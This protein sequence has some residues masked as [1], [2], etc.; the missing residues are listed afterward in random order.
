MLIEAG[1]DVNAKD[2]YEMTPKD[3]LASNSVAGNKLLSEH[4]AKWG[5]QLPA[6]VPQWDSD[7]LAYMGPGE[8]P[9]ALEKS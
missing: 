7:E 8:S 5:R 9:P 1:A 6:G 3:R 2:N 4:G